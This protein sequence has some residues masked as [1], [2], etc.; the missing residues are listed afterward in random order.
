MVFE[1]QVSMH[2]AFAIVVFV[3]KFVYGWE[4]AHVKERI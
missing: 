2:V 4:V 1:P 3:V